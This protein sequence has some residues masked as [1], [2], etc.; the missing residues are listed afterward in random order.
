VTTYRKE[1][2]MTGRSHPTGTVL[3]KP[4]RYADY[5]TGVAAW[6]KL[7]ADSTADEKSTWLEK[8]ASEFADAACRKAAQLQK[9]HC[10]GALFLLRQVCHELDYTEPLGI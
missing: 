1:L 6:R 9:G 7:T 2:L 5:D 4:L 10:C 8:T 3:R